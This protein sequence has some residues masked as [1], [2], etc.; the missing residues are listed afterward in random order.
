MTV[1]LLLKDGVD[2]LGCLVDRLVNRR[3]IA[4]HRGSRNQ[5]QGCQGPQ[6]LCHCCAELELDK[7]GYRYGDQLQFVHFD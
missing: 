6:L 5:L 7:R 1:P 3:V 2:G 4:Y